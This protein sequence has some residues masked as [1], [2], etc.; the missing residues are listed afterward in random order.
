MPTI[1][2]PRKLGILTKVE[3]RGASATLVVSALGLFSLLEP[4][5]FEP[6]T[7]LWPMA[8]EQMP[9]GTIFDAAMPKPCGEVLVAGFAR[10]PGGE[11]VP[12]LT[13]DIALGSMRKRLAVFGDRVWRQTA[14]GPVFEPPRPFTEMP[15]VPE[16][17]FGGPNHPVNPLGRG[18]E[19]ARRV[20]AGEIV[21]LPNIERADRLI[22]NADD[23]PESVRLGPIDPAHPSRRVLAG[24][25]DDHWLKHD[26][27][28]LARDADPRLFCVATPDQRIEGYFS[29][30]ERFRLA[31]FS[32]EHPVLE[33]ALPGMRA[34]IFIAR[35][36]GLFEL[37]NVL[38]TAWLFPSAHKGV[39]IYRGACPV[40]DIDGDDVTHIMLAYE[41]LADAPRSVEHY[42]EAFR[43]R[44]D[45]A[46][47]PKYVL[48]DAALS[49]LPD[50]AA[51]ERR[52]LAR[53]AHHERQRERTEKAQRLVLR[54][55][56][57]K[58]GLP[59]AFMPSLPPAEPPPAWMPSPDEI[60]S[61]EIDFAALFEGT[62]Q[63]QAQ[64]DERGRQLEAQAHAM[65]NRGERFRQTGE[66]GEL[67][68]LL[69]ELDLPEQPNLA[70][71]ALPPDFK[72][73][74][75]TIDPEAALREALQRFHSAP[76]AALL[77][78]ARDGLAGAQAAQRDTPL[79]ELAAAGSRQAIQLP[80]ETAA[81]RE[82]L[83][84]AFPDLAP[85]GQSLDDLLST[86]L[87][88]DILPVSKEPADPKAQLARASAQLDELEPQLGEAMATMR[89]LAPQPIHP[90]TP[91]P[92]EA[93]LRFG[94]A[95]TAMKGE[96]LAR[97]DMA[98]ANLSS[99]DFSGLDLSGAFFEQCDLRGA[100]FLGA[101]CA[102][103]VFA[104]A[105]LREADFSQANLLEA[106]F[107]A[108][109][110]RGARFAGADLRRVQW[111]KSQ[112]A[113][114]DFA[115]ATLEQANFIETDLSEVSFAGARLDR[116]TI[117]RSEMSRAVLADAVMESCSLVE[118]RADGL[119]AR[120]LKAFKLSAV[121]LEAP[122]ADFSGAHLQQCGFYAGCDL[123]GAR[124]DGAVGMNGSFRGT[125]LIRASFARSS[126]N[127]VDFGEADLSE[128]DL[129]LA[130]LKQASLGK[131][132]LLRADLFGANLFNA[133]A[134]R[135]HL[136]GARL[137][138]ANLYGCDL[139]DASLVGAD[140]TQALLDKTIFGM[141]SDAP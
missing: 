5:D 27:P 2:K 35:A 9:A 90:I 23:A 17:C 93:A 64:M 43:L 22:R 121:K 32:A 141:P 48:A 45:P 81:A 136:D 53:M 36:D 18:A 140:L 88:G 114:C 67:D 56:L 112:V 68:A 20:D 76:G 10:A 3:R 99:H 128:A 57:D 92:P 62:Q 6:D 28:G 122:G 102:G 61:G 37:P 13:L 30:Q 83:T 44:S 78:P 105:D 71:T 79:P 132:I 75:D 110:A 133:Q 46:E 34:R 124:F 103:A 115:G 15:L 127:R 55:A 11:S 39:L 49:P 85:P 59:A 24:T 72:L 73:P 95:I 130:S 77:A 113:Q 51:L 52:R 109:D 31:G 117:L 38:D 86:L 47:K 108:A 33:G 134:R 131:A 14:G 126:F 94:Q 58:A 50:P 96:G 125:R 97:R 80:A 111:L 1:I 119:D 69:A 42:T 16:R 120:R 106:N 41:R 101:N 74:A 7:A 98:G 107:G 40:S 123:T 65:A 139:S 66:L 21:L 82:K 135:A 137:L 84:R 63:L 104:G 91:L 70:A 29:G 138:R 100:R 129:S 89:R 12:A 116:V 25:Y 60:A 87:A 8:M 19:A 26:F 118:V 54:D 4:G